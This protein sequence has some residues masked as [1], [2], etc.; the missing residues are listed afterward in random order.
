MRR[1]VIESPLAGDFRKNIRYAR[2]CGLDCLKRG[3]APYASHL[4]MT[5]FLDDSLPEERELGLKAGFV[6][7]EVG[8]LVAVYE[9]LGISSGMQEGIER[10]KARGAAIEYR[11]LSEMLHVRFLAGLSPLMTYGTRLSN[12]W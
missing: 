3:E 2:F 4:L 9:D 1:V 7:G 6:W 10:A 11:R 5:Q 8:D 12:E